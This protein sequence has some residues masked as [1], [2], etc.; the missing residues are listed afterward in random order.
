MVIDADQWWLIIDANVL[1]CCRTQGVEYFAPFAST[2]SNVYR[3]VCRSKVLKPFGCVV[4]NAILA[5][6]PAFFGH[7]IQS[8]P[9]TYFFG[10]PILLGLRSWL[11]RRLPSGNLNRLLWKITVCNLIHQR[12]KRAPASSP[13]TVTITRGHT[14]NTAK[15]ATH[16]TT[17]LSLQFW[18]FFMKLSLFLMA[19]AHSNFQTRPL[20]HGFR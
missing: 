9:F 1:P 14:I 11:I 17:S 7:R 15:C 5:E 16:A 8:V 12:T 2:R 6:L 3:R 19:G 20:T 18:C 13:Q 4:E 10:C